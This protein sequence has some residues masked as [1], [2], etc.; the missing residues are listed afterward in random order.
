MPTTT[1]I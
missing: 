1:V